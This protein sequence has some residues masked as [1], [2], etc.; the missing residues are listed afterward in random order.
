[1]TNGYLDDKERGP[2]A[3]N[4]PTFGLSDQ[5]WHVTWDSISGDFTATPEKYGAP[6]VVLNAAGVIQCSFAFDQNGHINIAFMTT[7]QAK[8]YWYDTAL[9]YHVT[10]TLDAGVTTPTLTLDDKRTTQTQSSDI[11]LWY[12]IQ[13]PALTWNLYYRQQR[14]RFDTERL[15]LADTLPYIRKLGMHEGLRVQAEL[16]SLF[17]M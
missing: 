1:M 10:D 12:T 11:L 14:D 16:T 5:N 4:D 17:Y 2:R 15:L 9:G 3:L 13:Q 8:L 6:S 7:T